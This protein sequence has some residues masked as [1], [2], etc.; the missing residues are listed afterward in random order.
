MKE[1]EEVITDSGFRRKQMKMGGNDKSRA[2]PTTTVP[3][4]P[5]PA[6]KNDDLDDLD[7]MMGVLAVDLAETMT[8]MIS[9]AVVV[10]NLTMMMITVITKRKSPTTA[11]L[12]HFYKEQMMKRKT[13][14]LSVQLKNK[15]ILPPGNKHLN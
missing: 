12:S 6:P 2:A 3:K 9:L 1:K 15:K 10:K 8:K 7:D 11:T 13:K 5:K 4:R 14:L